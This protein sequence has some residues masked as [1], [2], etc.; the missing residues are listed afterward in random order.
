MC[1]LVGATLVAL[2]GVIHL[3]GFVVPW[4]VATV[5]GFP[6]RATALGGLAE[7]G[8]VGTR[9]V[10]VAW[11][12]CAVGFVVAGVGI[13]RRSPW[14]RR[15]TVSLAAVS[16]VLCVLALPESSVGI[17]VNAAIIAV[18]AWTAREHTRHVVVPS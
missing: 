13:A 15:L 1:R 14:A 18:A 17:L 4:R 12:V 5:D 9:M 10:G 8:D 3:I 2:H 11:L 16:I 6:Y 7:L